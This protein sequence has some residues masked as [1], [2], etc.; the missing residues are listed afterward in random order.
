MELKKIQIIKICIIG[1]LITFTLIY[2]IEKNHIKETILI[3]EINQNYIEKNVKIEGK[4][5]KQTLN[6]NTLF[7]TLKDNSSQ[8]NIIAFK[9]NQTLNKNQKYT[10]EGKVTNYNKKLEIIANKIEEKVS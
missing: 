2:L 9:T 6:K 5:T 8:I 3:S 10:I 7:L 1:F 4:I